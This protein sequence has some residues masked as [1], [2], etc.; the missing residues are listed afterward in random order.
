MPYWFLVCVD[1]VVDRGAE[2][3]RRVVSRRLSYLLW[4]RPMPDNDEGDARYGPELRRLYSA[5]YAAN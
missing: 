3:N 1:R 4:T 2:E 5:L